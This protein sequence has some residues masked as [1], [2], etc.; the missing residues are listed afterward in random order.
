M[1]VVSVA[2]SRS[3]LDPAM[4]SPRA[5]DFN[6]FVGLPWWD[7]GRS[8]G[9]CDCWGL[10]C[11]VYA[12]AGIA[13]PSFAGAYADT[14]DAA[15]NDLIADNRAGWAIVPQGRE[16]PLD[17]VLMHQRPWHV[18]IVVRRGLMLHM[19]E[20]KASVIEPYTTGRWSR[21]VEGVYRHSA[22]GAERP[23]ARQGTD[24]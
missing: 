14:S 20:E 21:R 6:A 7:R 1:R 12:A 24:K 11:L 17:L 18:G 13:L 23:K 19:P 4:A 8:R 2:G 3:H 10:A 16:K 15:I 9:G 5:V 22:R